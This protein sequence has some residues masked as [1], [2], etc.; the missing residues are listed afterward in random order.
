VRVE[1][2]ETAT[3]QE[4]GLREV[5]VLEH[6]KLAESA[7]QHT[8]KAR[9][10]TLRALIAENLSTCLSSDEKIEDPNEDHMEAM[11]T[12]LDDES[13]IKSFLDGVIEPG[14]D[15]NEDSENSENSRDASCL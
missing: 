11:D 5:A 12:G 13:A 4:A 15:F 1:K 7:M 6:T 9:N 2:V 3:R 10:H 8:P 14:S